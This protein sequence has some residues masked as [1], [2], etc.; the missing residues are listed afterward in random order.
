[1]RQNYKFKPQDHSTKQPTRTYL[2]KHKSEVVQ[3]FIEFHKLMK[4]TCNYNIKGTI[5]NK[6][7][8][9]KRL[10]RHSITALKHYLP[11]AKLSPILWDEAIIYA[12]ILG[13]IFKIRKEVFF[14][15]KIVTSKLK[16]FLDAKHIL[17]LSSNPSDKQIERG[18]TL[19]NINLIKS[20][21]ENQKE[22][23]GNSNIEYRIKILFNE[24][25]AKNS[26]EIYENIKIKDYNSENE[27]EDSFITPCINYKRTIQFI[28][29]ERKFYD[30][31]L[32]VDEI[33]RR[34]TSGYIFVSGNTE[35]S[36]IWIR[37][38]ENEIFNKNIK[39]D[40]KIDNKPSKDIAENEN[41]KGFSR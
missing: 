15:K 32:A 25:H 6:I 29:T 36:T 24:I 22:I 7:V 37:K 19:D 28:I 41:Q 21:V 26:T 20:L 1:M 38:L 34:S 13:L 14:N 31:N 9:L 27:S 8:S 23:L 18:T 16:S 30:A 10:I 40:I 33:K 12:C 4:N 3:K 39:I 5:P 2:L 17:F 11:A 35:Y